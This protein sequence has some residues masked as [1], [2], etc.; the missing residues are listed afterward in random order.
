MRLFAKKNLIEFKAKNKLIAETF[1]NLAK[2]YK[3]LPMPGYTHLQR[4]MPSSWGLWFSSYAESF[5][6]NVDLINNTIDWVDS[7]PLGSAIPLSGYIPLLI[8]SSLVARDTEITPS[9][10]SNPDGTNF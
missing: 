10:A 8:H 1:L 3:D 9:S 7:N 6:D 4:A 5:I 2:K